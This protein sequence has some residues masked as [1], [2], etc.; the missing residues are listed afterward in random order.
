MKIKIYKLYT[1]YFK[2]SKKI[3]LSANDSRLGQIPLK[4]TNDLDLDGDVIYFIDSSYDRGFNEAIEEYVEAL[5]KGRLFKYNEKTNKLE[6]LLQD[7]YFPNGLQL[8]PN[9]DVL[10]INENTMARI[11]RSI[12][13]LCILNRN[14][15]LFRNL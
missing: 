10:L 13:F 4:F 14:L 9:K 2:G 15:N 8:T 12:N 1:F 11:I 5:P 3:V 6:V 7:L